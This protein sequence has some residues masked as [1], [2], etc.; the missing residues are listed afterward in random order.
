MV[1]LNILVSIHLYQHK[2]CYAS[3]F[4]FPIYNFSYI[5]LPALYGQCLINCSPANFRYNL[6][7][8]YGD[9]INCIYSL[10]FLHNLFIS[11]TLSSDFTGQ[12]AKPEFQV[13][14]PKAQDNKPKKDRQ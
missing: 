4:V 5:R 12:L 6:F 1:Y 14:V 13:P 9:Y 7:I 10:A 8:F 11:D 3:S 2:L